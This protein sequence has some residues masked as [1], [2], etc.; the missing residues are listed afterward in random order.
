MAKMS[1]AVFAGDF[2]A[3][4]AMRVVFMEFDIFFV[5]RLVETWPAGAGVEFG[6]GGEEFVSAGDAGV[7]AFVFGVNIFSSKWRFRPFLSQN[8][9]LLR[10]EF[11]VPV[12]VIL[13]HCLVK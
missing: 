8:S 10:G 13:G 4:H 6:I 1:A 7:H 12:F 3:A 11:F 2:D 5:G 9:V